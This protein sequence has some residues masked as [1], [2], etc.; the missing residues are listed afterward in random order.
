ILPRDPRRELDENVFHLD[1]VEHG[2]ANA[3]TVMLYVDALRPLDPRG[4]RARVEV[5]KH[6]SNTEHQVAAF[7][8]STNLLVHQLAVIHS[9]IIRQCLIEHTFIP[10]HGREW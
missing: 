10:E 7:D 3:D 5:S 1:V 4:E 9:D 8:E 2:L 6:C